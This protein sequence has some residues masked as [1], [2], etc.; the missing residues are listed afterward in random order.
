MTAFVFG[1]R[2][3]GIM[4]RHLNLWL[5]IA[6]AIL[7]IIFAH[8]TQFF[9]SYLLRVPA[10]LLNSYVPISVIIHIRYADFSL[11]ALEVAFYA[12]LIYAVIR[13][14]SMIWN[15]AHPTGSFGVSS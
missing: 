2:R 4:K 1:K 3:T 13:L 9:V 6:G 7:V 12:L 11:S 14:F 10:Y 15:G 5:S 8:Q